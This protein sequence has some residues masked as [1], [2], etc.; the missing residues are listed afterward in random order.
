MI[1]NKQSYESGNVVIAIFGSIYYEVTKID[2]SV[3]ENTTPNYSIGSKDPTS[4]STGN[5]EY[6]ASISIRLQSIFDLE[7]AAGGNLLDIK[8]FDIVVTYVNDNNEIVVDKLKVKFTSQGRSLG[9]EG[10]IV[11]GFDLM[12]FGIDFNVTA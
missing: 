2:Y 3:K 8:P 6:S 4:W 11:F 9:N 7:K 12:C 10:D 5:R 1:I